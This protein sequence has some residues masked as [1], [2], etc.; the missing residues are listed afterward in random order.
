MVDH[1]EIDETNSPYSR[2]S[3]EVEERK[4]KTMIELTSVMLIESHAPLY[5]WGEDILIASY[6]FNRAPHKMYKLIT[7]ELFKC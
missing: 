2:T 4:N 7:F 5:F 6:M 3:N 1:W